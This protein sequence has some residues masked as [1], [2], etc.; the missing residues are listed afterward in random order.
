PDIASTLSNLG[1]CLGQQR[2]PAAALVLHRRALAIREKALPP[3]H[4]D[5]AASWSN[6]GDLHADLGQPAEARAHFQEALRRWERSLGPN[7][8]ALAFALL[9]IGNSL[10]AEGDA[11]AAVAPIE[12]ALALRKAGEVDV[13]YLTATRF[14]LARALWLADPGERA[15]ARALAEQS[16]AAA[17]HDL[18]IAAWLTEHPLPR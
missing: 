1:L 17:P 14:A 9:G 13:A 11:A 3:E 18:E 6:L 15:R 7:H 8:A 12:R 10:L 16:L 5:I 2:E 4:P